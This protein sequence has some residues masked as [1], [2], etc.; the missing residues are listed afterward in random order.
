MSAQKA[1]W[2]SETETRELLGEKEEKC[3]SPIDLPSMQIKDFLQKGNRTSKTKFY[4]LPA[5][6]LKEFEIKNLLKISFL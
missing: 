6:R 4:K 1:L 3:V 5:T 2:G